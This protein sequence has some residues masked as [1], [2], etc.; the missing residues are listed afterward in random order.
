MS[1]QRLLHTNEINDLTLNDVSRRALQIIGALLRSTR[2]F[3]PPTD[4]SPT[5]HALFH[6]PPR[7][8]ISVSSDEWRA[9]AQSL[10]VPSRAVASRCIHVASQ[11]YARHL[12]DEPLRDFWENVVIIFQKNLSQN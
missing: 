2:P 4:S 6:R 7:A 8:A 9:L 5:A 11:Q 12:Y 1:S 10:Q 3:N